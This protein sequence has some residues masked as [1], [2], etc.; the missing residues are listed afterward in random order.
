MPRLCW[1]EPAVDAIFRPEVGSRYL[2]I[3]GTTSHPTGAWTTQ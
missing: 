2:C 1:T 3:L